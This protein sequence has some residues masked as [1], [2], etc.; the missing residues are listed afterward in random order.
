MKTPVVT[1]GNFHY[2]VDTTDVGILIDIALRAKMVVHH[3]ENYEKYMLDEILNDPFIESMVI[4]DVVDY[5]EEQD[6]ETKNT[7]EEIFPNKDDK[8]PF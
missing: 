1:I 8:I 6:P 7:L 2:A 4:A 3:P 5:H